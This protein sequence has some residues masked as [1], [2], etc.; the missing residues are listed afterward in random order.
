MSKTGEYRDK[1]R[2]L[3]EWDAYLLAESGLPGP[4]GNIELAQVAA[5]TATNETNP[6][7]RIQRRCDTM[8]V[9]LPSYFAFMLRPVPKRFRA[10]CRCAEQR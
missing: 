1:L 5:A 8:S 10:P 2:S 9:K 7:I 4:R 3:G 6:A